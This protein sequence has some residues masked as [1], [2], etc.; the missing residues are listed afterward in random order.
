MISKPLFL[1]GKENQPSFLFRHHWWTDLYKSGGQELVK[2]KNRA[3][4]KWRYQNSASYQKIRSNA[5]EFSIAQ[6]LAKEVYA[7]ISKG[8]KSQKAIW[9]PLRN[10]A[11]EL[12][13]KGLSKDVIIAE[14]KLELIKFKGE[15]EKVK[16]VVK[17]P[18]IAKEVVPAYEPVMPALPFEKSEKQSGSEKRELD[19]EILLGRYYARTDNLSLADELHGFN[20]IMRELLHSSKEEEALIGVKRKALKPTRKLRW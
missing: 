10:K 12:V 13:R 11:Q 14:L 16:A 3:P 17:K 9:Y 6:R 18:A 20:T 15:V 8:K 2:T 1:Y 19:S 5:D 4:S 7:E